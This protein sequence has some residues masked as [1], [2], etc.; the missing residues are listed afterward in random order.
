MTS[1]IT[2]KTATDDAESPT[3]ARYQ[4]R[5]LHL[6]IAVLLGLVAA[7]GG[8]AVARKSTATYR[9]SAALS[10]DQPL[11]VAASGDPGQLDKLARIRLKYIGVTRYDVFVTAVAK[12]VALKPGKVRGDLVAVADRS[13]LL[14]VMGAR[15][16]N[17]LTARRI[18]TAAANEMV[19][20]VDQEQVKANIPAANRIVASVVVEPKGAAR[21]APTKRKEVTTAVVAGLIVFFLVVGLSSLS[22]RPR[23]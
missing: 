12:Q 10:F 22:H 21:I 3:R 2:Q 23:H 14:L 20:Y 7:A 1:T 13:S 6:M 15:D 9:S 19:A 5:V 8:Y 17:A 18:A 4:V 11:R 16:H